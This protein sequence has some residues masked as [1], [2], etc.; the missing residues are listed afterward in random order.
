EPVRDLRTRMA[1]AAERLRV[2]DEVGQFSDPSSLASLWRAGRRLDLLREVETELRDRK[3]AAD[4]AV[5]EKEALARAAE[6][7]RDSLTD[8]LR[9]SGGDRLETAQRELREAERRLEQVQGNR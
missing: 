5:A 6:D 9:A 3:Q 7:E 2:I 4:A 1:A 8:V